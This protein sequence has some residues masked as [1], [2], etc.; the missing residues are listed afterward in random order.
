MDAL[1]LPEH[2]ITTEDV[3][4]LKAMFEDRPGSAQVI[5]KIFYPELTAD[6]P[7]FLNE[8]MMTKLSLDNLTPEQKIIEVEAHQKLVRHVE[9]AL[10]VIR[11][12]IG[13]KEESAEQVLQRLQ[14]DSAK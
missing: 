10:S 1:Q 14:K 7:L 13:K 2:R 8:D 9:G 5:R 3:A 12:L 6:N 4:V 11:T